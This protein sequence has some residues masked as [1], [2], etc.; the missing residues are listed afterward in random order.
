M[1][2]FAVDHVDIEM[3]EW[4]QRLSIDQDTID[5]VNIIYMYMNITDI[6]QR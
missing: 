4:L 3:V 5:K 2:Y 1:T 6:N